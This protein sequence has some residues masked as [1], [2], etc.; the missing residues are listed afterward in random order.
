[1]PF[2]HGR[3]FLR[4]GPCVY[5]ARPVKAGPVIWHIT[6]NLA[7][8]VSIV[9]NGSVYVNHRSIIPKVPAIPAAANKANTYIAKTIV[10]APVITYV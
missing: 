7:I 3:A 2:V 8:N 1:M 9:Y 4:A 5:A 10:N 6:N